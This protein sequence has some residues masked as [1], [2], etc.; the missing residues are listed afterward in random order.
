MEAI[1]LTKSKATSH[2][3]L[4]VKMSVCTLRRRMGE[5]KQNSAR[6]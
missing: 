6:S 5:L 2:D 3:N 4:K 1:L